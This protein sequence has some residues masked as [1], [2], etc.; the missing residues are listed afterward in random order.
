MSV[1]PTATDANIDKILVRSSDGTWTSLL[2]T[3]GSFYAIT[4][5]NDR[6]FV[7][8]KAAAATEIHTSADNGVTWTLDE[9]LTATFGVAATEVDLFAFEGFLYCAVNNDSVFRRD[10]AGTWTEVDTA[11]STGAFLGAY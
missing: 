4:T 10:S 6:L 8:R 1:S 7:G 5:Y 9:D 2:D 11:P 3:S